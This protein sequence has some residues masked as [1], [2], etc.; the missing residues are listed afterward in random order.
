MTL[1]PSLA[2]LLSGVVVD[3]ARRK[4]R[5]E[6]NRCAM[7]LSLYIYKSEAHQI[8]SSNVSMAFSIC[9]WHLHMYICRHFELY[10]H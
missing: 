2:F 5:R 7:D 1:E 4:Y 8:V 10:L 6:V 3:E 9:T